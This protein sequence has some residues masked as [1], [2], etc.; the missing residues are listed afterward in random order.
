VDYQGRLLLAANGCTTTG[1]AAHIDTAAT[2]YALGTNDPQH[3]DVVSVSSPTMVGQEQPGLPAEI[4]LVQ[5]YPNP[6]NNS[7]VI[8]YQVADDRTQA[9]GN[10][11]LAIYDMLG[12]EVA[13]LVNERKEPGR[14]SAQ[15]D[16]SG[17]PSGVYVCRLLSGGGQRT[18]RMV[19]SH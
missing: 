12:R 10:V 13:V 5:N 11:H 8:A 3:M 2:T 16:A 6:F 7:T 14:Y 1:T 9:S 15:W 4:G 18:I 19:L 17:S